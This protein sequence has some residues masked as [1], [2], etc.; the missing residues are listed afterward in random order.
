MRAVLA[1][2]LR[3][4][5]KKTETERPCVHNFYALVKDRVFYCVFISIGL[6]GFFEFLVMTKLNLEV[7]IFTTSGEVFSFCVSLGLVFLIYI[8]IPCSMIYVYTREPEELEDE[9][10]EEKWGALYE[11]I[12]VQKKIRLTY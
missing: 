7:P 9:E 12:N 8:F 10:F 11:D 1:L 6:E 2:V 5:I 3:I 4:I